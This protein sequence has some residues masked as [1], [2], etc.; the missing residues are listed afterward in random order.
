MASPSSWTHRLVQP[1]PNVN[2]ALP[3]RLHPWWLSQGSA[4]RD[5]ASHTP[6]TTLERHS[7]SDA[8]S[9]QFRLDPP[10]C[11]PNVNR[12]LP[13]RRADRRGCA[14][15]MSDLMRQVTPDPV[16]LEGGG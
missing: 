15:S 7:C 14:L 11:A 2:R 3:I 10:C 16:A 5:D 1:E 4:E 8:I 12:A 13:I 6:P 9:A